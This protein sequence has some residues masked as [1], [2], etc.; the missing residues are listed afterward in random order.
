MLYSLQCEKLR[1]IYSCIFVFRSPNTSQSPT[2]S[3]TPVPQPRP[4]CEPRRSCPSHPRLV[5]LLHHHSRDPPP[6]DCADDLR[7][8]L[9]PCHY[10]LFIPHSVVTRP[11]EAVWVPL[12][13][14]ASR[15]TS[16]SPWAGSPS[17]RSS[18]APLSALSSRTCVTN[19]PCFPTP[20]ADPQLIRARILAIAR[21]PS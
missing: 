18:S 10:P 19:A 2:Q 20:L 15:N 16:A 6:I 1:H 11:V 5:D 12:L 21:S 17:S 3:P 7:L 8:G 14:S 4:C 9:H 13:S